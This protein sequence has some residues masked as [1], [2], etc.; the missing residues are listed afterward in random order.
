MAGSVTD[1]E[2]GAGPGLSRDLEGGAGRGRSGTWRAERGGGD[3]G[4]GYLGI[5]IRLSALTSL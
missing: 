5:W 3:Q 1:L 4:P 2:G